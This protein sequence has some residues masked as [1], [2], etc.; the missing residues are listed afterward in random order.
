MLAS[1]PKPA[2]AL[3]NGYSFRRAITVSS[4][5]VPSTQLNF[6]MLVTGTFSYLA[7]AANGGAIQNTVTSNSQAVPADLIFTS[8]P[9]GSSLLKWEIASYT[10]ATGAI[11]LWIQV[12]SLSNGAV[13]YM[14]YGNPAATIY[15]GNVFGAW[16]S[17]FTAVYHLGQNPVGTPPQMLDS[18]ANGVHLTTSVSG[19]GSLST[20]AGQIGNA[21]YLNSPNEY[22][23]PKASS[24]LNSGSGTGPWT[25]SGWFLFHSFNF[26]DNG[27]NSFLGVATSSS[28]RTLAI[29]NS[30]TVVGLAEGAS[31]A[32]QTGATGVL[33]T[34]VWYYFNLTYDG[35][36]V[37]LYQNGAQAGTS[38]G[39]SGSQADGV[40]RIGEFPNFGAEYTNA[41]SDEVH[42]SKVARSADWIS[43]EYNNQSNPSG[44]YTIGAPTSMTLNVTAAAGVIM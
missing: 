18:T 14:F 6:P 2:A 19:T 23:G 22:N 40:V 8:D 37:R 44:F 27:R 41:Y 43:T 15:A 28:Y 29:T 32:V 12:P 9:A 25:L 16:D 42:F 1:L 10:P 38:A 35:T 21:L 13:V 3:A 33:T 26:Y 5:V 7:L 30:N 11:E 4:S 20:V 24:T 17:N 36:T 31:T 34:G 39:P